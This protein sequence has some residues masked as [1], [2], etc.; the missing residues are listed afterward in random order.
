MR[1]RIWLI[2][3]GFSRFFFS[4]SLYICR[5]RCEMPH[6]PKPYI[7]EEIDRPGARFPAGGR[8]FRRRR[9]RRHLRLG[10]RLLIG[11]SVE[12][13]V[14]NGRSKCAHFMR[15]CVRAKMQSDAAGGLLLLQSRIRKRGELLSTRITGLE[16]VSP[17]IEVSRLDVCTK[18]HAGW[19][20]H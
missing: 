1:F 3:P 17:Q 6:T 12:L 15:A 10:G 18:L 2:F 14:A 11:W 19:C 7:R 5:M 9:C 4:R 8:F 16:G 20:K 13:S